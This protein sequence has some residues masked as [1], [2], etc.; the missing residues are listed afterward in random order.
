VRRPKIWPVE[1]LKARAR[2]WLKPY[3]TCNEASVYEAKDRKRSTWVVPNPL[4]VS[5]TDLASPL[6]F[7]SPLTVRFIQPPPRKKRRVANFAFGFK[8]GQGPPKFAGYLFGFKPGQ[9][10]PRVNQRRRPRRRRGPRRRRQQQ[11]APTHPA[12]QSAMSALLT[13]TPLFP[14]SIV[15]RLTYHEEELAF[16]STSGVPGGYVFSANGMYDPNITSS[17][18][19]PLGFDQMMLMYEQYTVVSSKITVD[20]LNSNNT[21]LSRAT[22]YLSPDAVILSSP[23]QALENGLIKTVMLFP[24][25]T[26]LSCKQINMNCD[27]RR[28]FGR[29]RSARAL[30]NDPD[31]FGTAA[32]NPSEQAYFVISAWDPFGANTL[33][34]FLNVTVEYT[35]VFWEPRKLTES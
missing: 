10:P 30:V 32:S 33:S 20:I 12:G 25:T 35:A 3:L 4:E 28:Y 29:N 27:I 7:F 31:L 19:Q 34:Y 24:N 26:F 9:G 5:A 15:R 21:A 16:T 8:P 23:N 2:Q 17:G 11:N 6:H 18:H 13:K 22:V 14:A 1:V